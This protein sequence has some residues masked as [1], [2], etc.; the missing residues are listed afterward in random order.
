VFVL[1]VPHGKDQV[2]SGVSPSGTCMRHFFQIKD[3]QSDRIE[4]LLASIAANRAT[5]FSL[6]YME[7]GLTRDLC[8]FFS[9]ESYF[10]TA[11][12]AYNRISGKPENE[13]LP[14]PEQENVYDG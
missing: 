6:I 11:T 4:T 9:L 2:S 5:M 14:V 12:E 3:D 7:K 1:T 13:P 10:K 8:E